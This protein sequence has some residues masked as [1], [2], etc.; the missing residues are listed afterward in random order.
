MVLYHWLNYFVS[1]DGSFYKYLRFLTPS[2]IFITGF[3]VS[4]IYL[5]KYEITD[6][7]LAK[8]LLQRGIK[9]FT[10]F[11]VL[12]AALVLVGSGLSGGFGAS[13]RRE[14]VVSTFLTGNTAAGRV[15]AFSILVPISYLLVLSSFLLRVAQFFPNVFRAAALTCLL[16]IL[17]LA[18][19]GQKSAYLEL[20]T[21]G[22][23]GVCAGYIPPERT[24]ALV[25]RPF[26]LM[27][28]YFA[29]VA[30]ITKWNE[31]YPLQIFGVCLTLALLYL[32]GSLEPRP[33]WVRNA[34]IL[35]GKYSLFGY[36][37]H[38]VILKLLQKGLRALEPSA[39]VLMVSLLAAVT[40]TVASVAL[41]D[42]ARSKVPIINKAYGAAFA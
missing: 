38:I 11:L 26:G 36:I 37:C 24:R 30:A 18:L 8:R 14:H 34:V 32:A 41:L 19:A 22:L 28:L 2:F 33:Q 6:P 3:L 40:L 39:G 29:Y 35:L 1:P 13:W 9:L 17:L 31:I 5:M 42:R 10:L 4:H 12:N 23:L 7:R 25:S 15:A 20:I 16:A 21:I 27:L